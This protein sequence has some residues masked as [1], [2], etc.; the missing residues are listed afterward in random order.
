MNK[1]RAIQ[2]EQL[3]GL[4]AGAMEPIPIHG[5]FDGGIRFDVGPQELEFNETADHANV[6]LNKKRQLR[7]IFPETIVPVG[8]AVGPIGDV[9]YTVGTVLKRDVFRVVSGV[10]LQIWQD[11]PLLNNW[12]TVVASPTGLWEHADWRAFSDRVWFARGDAPATTVRVFDPIGLTITDALRNG[13]DPLKARYLGLFAN[14]LLALQ[15]EG[16]PQRLDYCVNGDPTDWEGTGSNVVLLDARSDAVDALIGFQPLTENVGALFREQ[17]IMRVVPTGVATP[18]LSIVPWIEELGSIPQTSVIVPGGVM[19]VGLDRM[20]YY[21]T[22]NGPQA[23][24]E[25]IHPDLVEG[26]EG[27]SWWATFDARTLTYYLSRT[28]VTRMR[29]YKLDFAR[30]TQ[31]ETIWHRLPD[32]RDLVCWAEGEFTTWGGYGAILFSRTDTNFGLDLSAYG[33]EESDGVS[34]G[35]WVSPCLNREQRQ[36]VYEL[37]EVVIRYENPDSPADIIIEGSGDGGET[38]VAAYKSAN[39]LATTAGEI[40]RTFTGLNVSG[41]D[42][43]FR[44]T[45][46]GAVQG[47]LRDWRASIIDRG[48]LGVF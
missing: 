22:Q 33:Y 8:G 31:G 24:G 30:M 43:R 37:V 18:A 17:S 7:T 11:P 42:L 12:S 10:G 46:N 38:W 2:G 35:Y 47:R 13:V 26:S 6:R 15:S 14:R 36:A 32:E 1:A 21:L 34:S 48:D 45:F 5:R 44:V 27:G 39:T 28:N 23:V 29:T 41:Q 25:K 4:L 16:D 40:A 3:Q 20:V 9:A 19:F